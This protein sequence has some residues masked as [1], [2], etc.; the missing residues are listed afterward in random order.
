MRRHLHTIALILFVL[1]F[2]FDLVLWGTVPGLPDVGTSIERSAHAEA[3]LASLYLALGVPLDAAV[4]ALHSL[5][6]GIMTAGLSPGFERILAE[7]HVA[8]DLIFSSS[9]NATH[10]LIKWLYWA[11]PVL[12]VLYVLLWIMRPKQVAFIKK[13]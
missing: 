5:G 7:P 11:A 9:F 8:M 13:R 1:V 10:G 2:L 3:V 4:G 12:L 6:T